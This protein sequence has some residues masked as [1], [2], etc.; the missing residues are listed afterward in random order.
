[1]VI[2]VID[3]DCCNCDFLNANERKISV[4]EFV[5]GRGEVEQ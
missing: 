2:N 5:F 1:M 3:M 4:F